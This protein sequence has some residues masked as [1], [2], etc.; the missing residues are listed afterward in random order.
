MSTLG[1]GGG[2]MFPGGSGGGFSPKYPGSQS[3]PYAS[4]PIFNKAPGSPY[5][6]QASS[7]FDPSQNT[8]PSHVNDPN[9]GFGSMMP[10]VDANG[11]TVYGQYQQAGTPYGSPMPTVSPQ[12]Q[13][14]NI[15]NGLSMLP[16]GGA[17]GA[18]LMARQNYTSQYGLTPAEQSAANANYASQQAMQNPTAGSQQ[19]YATNTYGGGQTGAQSPYS[20]AGLQ[21][22]AGNFGG[23]NSLPTG[24]APT[25]GLAP[26]TPGAS[27]PGG[28]SPMSVS[29]ATPAQAADM[30]TPAAAPVG[31]WNTN[32]S[33]WQAGNPAAM[34]AYR[35]SPLASQQQAQFSAL[36]ASRAGAAANPLSTTPSQPASATASQQANQRYMDWW[37]RTQQGQRP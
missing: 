30:H 8:Q 36:S 3:G 13:Q 25:G 21:S 27:N 1:T 6:G 29:K 12:Q 2:Q 32:M 20:S 24:F 7:P 26:M 17:A 34:A 31:P 5:G 19:D 4:P 15:S 33:P 35:A 11:Q 18:D 28:Q 37:K 14:A 23:A 22:L 9:G 16:D 10:H